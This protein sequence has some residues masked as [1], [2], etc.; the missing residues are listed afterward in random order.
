[1]SKILK[2]FP[3]P[4]GG[5]SQQSTELMLD[6][7]CLEMVNCVPDIVVGTQRRNGLNYKATLN[8]SSNIF[9]F[10]DRGE[11]NEQ[12]FTSLTGIS[13]SPLSVS[14]IM[15]SEKTITYNT[16]V[17]D[18]N[19]YLGTDKTVLK[20][21]TVQDRTF[22]VNTDKTVGID[23]EDT[24]N[25]LYDRTAYYWLSRSSND[26][27]APYNYA[28]YLD[29]YTFE[30]TGSDSDDAAKLLAAKIVAAGVGFTATASGS[31]V[32]IT[33]SGYKVFN[34]N[35]SLRVPY[36]S[37][38]KYVAIRPTAV[39]TTEYIDVTLCDTDV[40][41]VEDT[42]CYKMTVANYYMEV[43]Q[44]G[45]TYW[46]KFSELE[47]FGLFNVPYYK[48]LGSNYTDPLYRIN[49]DCIINQSGEF[50]FSSWDSWGSQ[51]STGWKGAI[52]KLSDLPREMPFQYAIVKITGDDSNN[53]TDYFVQYD[54]D[55]WVET[56]NPQ[57]N[58]GSFTNMPIYM[59]RRSDGTFEVGVLPWEL[60]TVGG[61]LTNPTPSFVN[62]TINDIFFYKNRLGFAASANVILSETG[63]Y[64]NF[65]SQT[66]L[67]VLDDDPIDVSISSNEATIIYYAIPF[68][69]ALF[70]FTKNSQYALETPNTAT[71]SP[72][73]VSFNLISR[74]PINT[75][76]RPINAGSSLFF[77]SKTG[78]NASQLREY[79][80][81]N[82]SL[83][84]DGVDLSVQV[85]N[86]LPSI[87]SIDVDINLGMV[88]MYSEDYKNTLYC[89]KY[90][91]QGSERVQS[92]FYKWVFGFDLNEIYVVNSTLYTFN[93]TALLYMELLT[94]DNTK[95]DVINSNLDSEDYSSYFT[96]PRWNIKVG[97]M[98]TPIK[99]IVMKTLRLVGDGTFD[100]DIYRKDYGTTTTRT[101]DS[102][103]TKDM[104]ASILS[105]NDKVL[106]TVKSNSDN[107]FKLDSM[108][109]T[110]MY[111][112][113]ERE[114]N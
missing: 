24:P 12:Y 16:D 29:T 103:S 18:I 112:Q 13:T 39:G 23:I 61:N 104:S 7:Q 63:G 68:Q 11:G 101:Y 47:P 31:I 1:M 52:A 84:A 32:Q 77:I 62:T 2:T 22:I 81:N 110:G 73:T 33:K 38:H 87:D 114:I 69:R 111:T 72:L 66:I 80:F 30:Q 9:H 46:K 58:R 90:L 76:V 49:M 43:Q 37:I 79:K 75:T 108:V 44:G 55:T 36:D 106:I 97:K 60:P 105:K 20:A 91:Q 98:E 40:T 25:D 78:N 28:V 14:D 48:K 54:G 57:D 95:V 92:S 27:N 85:P 50:T 93:D 56:R 65:Y 17:N 26:T 41:P 45:T 88:F 15:G 10:Y 3:S 86:Y 8:S 100:V 94:N 67:E 109:L 96:L 51:A 64:Y 6:Q 74:L 113:R 70:V 35:G 99:T 42:L 21:I 19:T 59:D 71:F 4:Y 53:F 34:S 89:Y 83:I 107:N 82:D 102:G 5:V